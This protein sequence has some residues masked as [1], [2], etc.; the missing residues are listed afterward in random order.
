MRP[1][2]YY[3]AASMDGFIA[4]PDGSVA[5]LANPAFALPGEDYGYAAL[6][7]AIDTTLMGHATYRVVAGFDGPFPYPETDNLVFTRTAGRR[8][9]DPVRFT[10]EEPVVVV[11]GLR[12]AEG[13][14]IWLVGG[15]TLAGTLLAAGRVDRVVATVFPVTLG[16]G[17]RLFGEPGT[18]P[19]L[20]WANARA[21]AYPNGAVQYVLERP[22]QP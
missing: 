21:T 18:H 17:V 11:D 5:W 6:L 9:E 15:G 2:I 3:V 4:T 16:A 1:V 10:T 7:E 13:R 22:V 12:R 14:A 20:R 8:A 19:P